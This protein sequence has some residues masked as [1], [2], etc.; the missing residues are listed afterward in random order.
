MTQRCRNVFCDI[1]KCSVSTFDVQIVTE[2]L[3]GCSSAAYDEIPEQLIQAG[4]EI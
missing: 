4:G 2:M 1:S 3:T